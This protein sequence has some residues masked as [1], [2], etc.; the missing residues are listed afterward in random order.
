MTNKQEL[1][2]PTCKI[3]ISRLK[4][5]HELNPANSQG[6]TVKA[7]KQQKQIQHAKRLQ[8]T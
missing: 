6:C 4:V 2:C 1:Q 5:C 7:S 3:K 8:Q